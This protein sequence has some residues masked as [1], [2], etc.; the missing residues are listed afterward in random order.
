MNT[1]SY[2]LK[3]KDYTKINIYLNTNVSDQ[4]LSVLMISFNKIN[5]QMSLMLGLTSSMF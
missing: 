2:H 3:V 5:R 4:E 1:Q